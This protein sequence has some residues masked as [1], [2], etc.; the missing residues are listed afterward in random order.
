MR[1]A[2]FI[3]TVSEG[4][5]AVIHVMPP[6]S[7]K[8]GNT[9]LWPSLDEASKAVEKRGRRIAGRGEVYTVDGRQFTD[10]APDWSIA[11]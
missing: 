7:R 4:R 10:R 11:L 2:A 6:V 1:Y 5:P 9:A 3:R 8:Y